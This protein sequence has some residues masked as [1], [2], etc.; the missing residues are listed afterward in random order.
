MQEGLV[1]MNY[2][3][4]HVLLLIFFCSMTLD[5]TVLSDLVIC[6]QHILIS[7]SFPVGQSFQK[8]GLG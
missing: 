1:G 8:M 7:E 4:D 2:V 3:M 5:V 6:M